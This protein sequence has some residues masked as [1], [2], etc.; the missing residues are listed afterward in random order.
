[1]GDWLISLVLRFVEGLGISI[2]GGS[3]KQLVAHYMQGEQLGTLTVLVVTLLN[4]F[5][6][7]VLFAGIAHFKVGV[8]RICGY[9]I[10]ASF[11]KPWLATN[12]VEFWRRFT[13]HYREFLVRAFYY[14]AFFRFFK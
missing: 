5:K 13:F 2:H 4:L 12:L 11:D 9:D 3:T 6:W 7:I 14:P 8:W 1:M 10:A